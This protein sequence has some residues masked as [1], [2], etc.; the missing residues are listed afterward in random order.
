MLETLT[1]TGPPHECVPMRLYAILVTWQSVNFSLTEIAIQMC[2]F[3]HT[4]LN[5]YE[6]T[7][8]K[9]C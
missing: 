3:G 2:R 4:I 7:P 1:S 6:S 5:S 8:A 9:G